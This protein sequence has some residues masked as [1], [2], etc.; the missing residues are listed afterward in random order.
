MV[1]SSTFNIPEAT[2]Y[3]LMDNNFVKNIINDE[4]KIGIKKNIWKFKT[5]CK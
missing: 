5:K 2:Y 1:L 3:I 4:P